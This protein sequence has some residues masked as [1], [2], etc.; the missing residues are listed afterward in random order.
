MNGRLID[1]SRSSGAEPT[2]P[3][4]YPAWR[5][6][7]PHGRPEHVLRAVEAD[8]SRWVDQVNP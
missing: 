5:P 8:V 3:G 7:G 4:A 1:R 6:C 2:E